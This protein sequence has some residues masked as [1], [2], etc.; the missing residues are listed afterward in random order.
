MAVGDDAVEHDL[1]EVGGFEFE[2][3][4]DAGAADLVG[5]LLQVV[6]GA[7][8]AAE[9]GG[10]E[11]LAVG[12]EEVE[13]GLVGAG[14]DLDE[15]GEA[16][17]DLGDWEGAK[18]GEVKECV[19]GGMV[20]S[21]TVLVVAIVDG[22]LDGD[23][24]VDEAD[25]GGGD[26]DEV[27]VAAVGRTCKPGVVLILVYYVHMSVEVKLYAFS[28]GYHKSWYVDAGVCRGFC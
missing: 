7:V 13:G 21:E 6:R 23:G 18:E 10:D 5:G 9:A 1:V 8:C 22:N 17:A 11:V 26:A 4:V 3:L 28:S 15:L 25:D 16:I 20:G 24:G 14:G 12:V 27:G 2:H 19:D